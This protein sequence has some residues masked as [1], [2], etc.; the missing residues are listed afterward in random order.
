MR[1]SYFEKLIRY[2]KNVYHVDKAFNDLTDKRVYP[3]YKTKQIATLIMI[4]FMLRI[5]SFNDLKFILERKKFC[6]LYREGTKFPKIDTFRDSSKTMCVKFLQLTQCRFIKTMRR[7]KVFENGTIAGRMVCAI[8]GTMLFGSYKKHCDS[9]LTTTI[10]GRTFYYHSCTVMSSIGNGPKIVFDFEMQNPAI[11][12]SSKD[13]GEL[14]AS[15]RLLK[16]VAESHQGLVD[17]VFTMHLPATVSG[18]T[19]AET[20]ELISL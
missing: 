12:P 9:C 10:K 2:I 14:N 8:D 16:R 13:E 18:S 1:D 6:K 17:I 20:L 5:E 3:E 7:N 11:D 4:A 15:K 19:I